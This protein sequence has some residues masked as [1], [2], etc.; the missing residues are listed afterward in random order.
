MGTL[1]NQAPRYDAANIIRRDWIDETLHDIKR[2]AIQNDISFQDAIEVM[3]IAAERERF[4]YWKN[5]LDI[6]DEQLGGFG[7]LL[8]DLIETIGAKQW[9]ASTKSS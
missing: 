7:E 5:D 2:I 4:T 8:S 9:Q 3:K 6:R 1:F